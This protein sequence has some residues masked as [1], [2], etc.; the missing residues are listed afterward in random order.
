M[1]AHVHSLMQYTN[2]GNLRI[3]L[4][5]IDHMG[6]DGVFE[7]ALANVSM[8]ANLQTRRKALKGIED[9][10]MVGLRLLY[11]PVFNGIAPDLFKIRLC[12]R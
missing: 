8:T 9:T 10:S 4:S 12:K 2:D 3:L 5:I 11:R 1:A 7:I 6:P